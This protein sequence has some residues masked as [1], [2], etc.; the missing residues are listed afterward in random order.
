MLFSKINNI[1]KDEEMSKH[2]HVTKRDGSNELWNVDKFRNTLSYSIDGVEN[3]SIDEL[4]SHISLSVYDGIPTSELMKISIESA[5]SLI[6]P[7]TPNWAYVAGKLE[8]MDLNKRVRH[9]VAK[10]RGKEVKR[11]FGYN[12]DMVD[13]I[14]WFTYNGIWYDTLWD[15]YTE[16]EVREV[17]TVLNPSIDETYSYGTLIVMESQ[18]LLKHKGL[19]VE[20][21]QEMYLGISLFLAPFMVGDKVE[22]AKRIYKKISIQKISP[23]TPIIANIRTPSG[24][25]TSCEVL[26]VPD[27][28]KGIEYINSMIMDELAMGTG[29]GV[30]WGLVRAGGSWVG[31]T[32][33][34]AGGSIPYMKIGN[35]IVSATDQKDIRKGNATFTTD[36]WHLDLLP[37]LKSKE[38]A[39]DQRQK[40]YDIFRSVA[41]PDIFMRRVKSKEE[42]T[43]Y[44]PY[45]IRQ[46]LGKDLADFW[47]EEFEEKYLYLEE[48]VR[49]GDIKLFEKVNAYELFKLIVSMTPEAGDPMFYYRDTANRSHANK[50]VGTI[51]SSNLCVTGDTKILTKEHGNMEIG[52]LVESG[53]ENITCW[54][55]I[56]WS[57]STI[58]KTSESQ[59]V[60][61]VILE[62]GDEIIKTKATPY[63]KWYIVQEVDANNEITIVEKRTHE[64]NRGDVLEGFVF[65]DNRISETVRVLDVVDEDEYAPT[66]CANEPYRN[67]VIF[68]G[69]LTGNCHEILS[70]HTPFE[71]DV[72]KIK[73][74]GQKHIIEY[75]FTGKYSATCNL[76][77][78]N[79]A[80]LSFDDDSKLEEEIYY[81]VNM[82]S[83]VVSITRNN[84]P[85]AQNFND[86]FNSIGVGN[87]G[88]A[89]LLAKKGL[90]YGS[91]EALE[92]TDKI[93]EKIAYYVVKASSRIAKERG[94]YKKFEGSDWQKGIF[95]GRSVYDMGK[96][97]IDL[98][99]N[100]V[101]PYGVYNGYMM[102]IAPNTSTSI[103]CHE[104]PS[105]FA[106]RSFITNKTFTKGKISEPLPDLDK[107]R[108]HY[109]TQNRITLEQYQD[110][111]K[112][113]QNWVDQSISMEVPLN[114]NSQSAS[115]ILK[116][117][118]RSWRIGLKTIYYTKPF[119]AGC[120]GCAN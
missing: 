52:E 41:V 12:D 19:E 80:K 47:G 1:Q 25:A 95:F 65:P 67:K 81:T 49:I 112:A 6:S 9:N 78:L 48:L 57:Y 61:K 92:F 44:D 24:S 79:L 63:H 68:N 29:L 105:I 91:P 111:V 86:D 15:M 113:F 75:D 62:K 23:A 119:S 53:V 8:N 69:V 13:I 90:M 64:L 30:Y 14:K 38:E 88:Y 74:E 96:K 31:G 99:E 115:D 4:E 21:P 58:F 117:Y 34:A 20:L 43:L 94:A 22:N 11:K 17:S 83:A 71:D 40:L 59:K 5:K 107:L 109:V 46:K 18:Y 82:L 97:W 28:L 110:T 89:H 32:E 33:N 72:V 35:D 73:R 85:M 103:L 50:H 114:I 55:G 106:P 93:A 87:I 42:W 118:Y 56:E 37:F 26:A 98:Y 70:V 101:K 100:W 51:Y 66:Y 3:V 2:I 54:N 27:N 77:S 60:L 76:A 7:E 102:A 39:G 108:W 104:T 36:I 116:F 84:N 120:S 45:E 16:E 10:L